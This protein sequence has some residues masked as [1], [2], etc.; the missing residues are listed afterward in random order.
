M[1]LNLLFLRLNLKFLTDEDLNKGENVG[2]LSVYLSGKID[3]NLFDEIS[4]PIWKKQSRYEK[5][6]I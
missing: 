3:V 1:V 6:D 4:D 2:E 5:Y